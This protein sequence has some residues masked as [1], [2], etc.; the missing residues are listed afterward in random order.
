MRYRRW[1]FLSRVSLQAPRDLF[2]SG[3]N[4]THLL[5]QGVNLL[6][7][8]TLLGHAHLKTNFIIRS[9]GKVYQIKAN[10]MTTLGILQGYFSRMYHGGHH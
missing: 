10:S 6:V 7:I 8:Q 2:P 5:D 1:P 3:P 4:P 9:G